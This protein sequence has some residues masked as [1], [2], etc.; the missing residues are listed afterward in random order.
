M[1]PHVRVISVSNAPRRR[2]LGNLCL[3]A[4]AALFTLGCPT[5]PTPAELASEAARDLNLSARWGQ[6]DMAAARTSPNARDAFFK[7]RAGWG[8]DVRVIDTELAGLSLKDSS[9][10]QVQVDVSWV[11]IDEATLRITRIE[12]TWVDE[13][14]KW[15]MKKEARVGGDL[16]LF[17]E[18]VERPLEERRPDAQFPT[19]VIR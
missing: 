17:G 11:R 10:A 9:H 18:K 4:V 6:I 7:N 3:A 12:Q 8:H 16:G 19:R 2:T 14:G 1:R 5:P 15:Q 13:M